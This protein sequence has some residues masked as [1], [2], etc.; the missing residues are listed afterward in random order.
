MNA[1][2]ITGKAGE[3]AACRL[4]EERGM[5]IIARNY[6]SGH[7]ELDIVALD[8]E[9]VHIVEVRTRLDN[10]VAPS[11]TVDRQ[12]QAKVVAAAKRFLS[13]NEKFAAYEIFFEGMIRFWNIFQRPLYLY[14][15]SLRYMYK[16]MTL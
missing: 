2:Q 9:G 7:Y 14:M 5:M 13:E 11:S 1:R 8:T 4:L 6:R 3:D 12:K 16:L 15:Y 10:A